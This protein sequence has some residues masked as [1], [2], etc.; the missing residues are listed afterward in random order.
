[1]PEMNSNL[2]GSDITG[3]E[4]LISLRDTT[5]YAASIK[6]LNPRYFDDSKDEGVAAPPMFAIAVT[7]PMME[8]LQKIMLKS[9]PPEIIFTMVHATEHLIFHVKT[10]PVRTWILKFTKVNF[11][12]AH[13]IR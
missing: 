2:V 9:Y 4:R 11:T 5:N 12:P 6:D 13:F 3:I 7:W 1:M 10:Y 8:N